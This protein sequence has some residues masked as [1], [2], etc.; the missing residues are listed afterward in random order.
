MNTLVVTR[1]T[2]PFKASCECP[3]Q[4]A[5][6]E[7]HILL[8]LEAHVPLHEKKYLG[9]RLNMYKMMSEGCTTT[10][11]DVERFSTL[12]QSSI[13][14][15]QDGCRRK[16]SVRL[17]LRD[18]VRTLDRNTELKEVVSIRGVRLPTLSAIEFVELLA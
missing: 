13:A 4:I 5:A 6:S 12:L 2:T 14:S 16:L 11:V 18:F 10:K 1:L 15:P 17:C 3:Y 9:H 8:R 7:D